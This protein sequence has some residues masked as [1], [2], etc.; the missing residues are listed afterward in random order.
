MNTYNIRLVVFIFQAVD[1]QHGAQNEG[2]SHSILIAEYLN[3]VYISVL[4]AAIERKT[5]LF[6]LLLPFVHLETFYPTKHTTV[7]ITYIY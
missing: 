1:S 3:T 2:L 5:I 7:N 4:L 6:D